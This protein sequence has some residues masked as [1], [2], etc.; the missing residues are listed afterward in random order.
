MGRADWNINDKWRLFIRAVRDKDYRLEPYGWSSV[1]VSNMPFGSYVGFPGKSTVANL[2]TVINPTLTN[3]FIFGVSWNHVYVRTQPDISP[4]YYKKD[5]GLSYQMPFPAAD[6]LG[7]VQSWT[8]GGVPNGPSVNLGGN[9][10][11]N[12]NAVFE[13]T[14]NLSKVY[15]SDMFK[16]GLFIH[17]QRKNQTAFSPVNGNISF[18]RDSGNPADSN[19][20]FSNALLGNYTTVQQADI[21]RNGKYRYT[22]A[23]WYLANTWKVRPNLTLD[24]GLRFYIV[25]PQYDA[26]MQLSSF[27]V[28]LWDPKKAALLYRRARDPAGNIAARDPITGAHYPA[29]FIGGLVPGTGYRLGDAYINGIAMAGVNDY[30]RGLIDSRGLHYAPRVGL[31]WSFMNKTVFRMGGGV[32]YDRFQG[33][34]CYAML[35]NPPATVTPTL[36][37]GSLTNIASA[38]SMLFPGTIRGFS[39]DGHVS[40]VYNYNAGL[41]RELPFQML[42]D[43]SYVGNVGRHGLYGY[44]LNRPGFGSAW[45]PQNQDPT[46]TPKFDGTTTLPVNFYRPYQ[47]HGSIN[48]YEFGASSNYNSLQVS[49]NRRLATGLQLGVAYT[50]SKSLGI[51]TGDATAM[52]PTNIRQAMYAPNGNDR[53]HILVFNYIYNT[54]KLARSGNVLDNWLGRAVF[55]GW[56]VSGITT[57]QTGAPDSVSYSISGVSQLARLVTGDETWGPRVVLTGQDPF[58]PKDK[59]NENSWFTAGA[60][61]P[62]VKPSVGLESAVRGYIYGPG[63]NHWDVSVF[64]SFPFSADGSRFVQLRLEMFNAPNHT[65]YSG[66]NTSIVFDSAGKVTNLPTALGGGGG[67]F[68]FGAVTSARDPR[69]IQLAAKI[70]F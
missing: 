61:A 8:W 10:F 9:P 14:D 47:G 43:V 12:M 41:Q 38:T 15:S 2:T 67:R 32:F 3:E 55:N 23:E 42:L 7:V 1:V 52:H 54:P 33:N 56:V 69:I 50:W 46:T 59:R 35:T 37:Y 53:R 24:L 64:K 51:S 62:A 11:V 22:N 57:I 27:N 45:L 29:A 16:F 4:K 18:A 34:P 31:A 44:D 60:F 13:F 39:K 26:G 5:L 49:L 28:E 30:P 58:V 63:T 68:G 70:Y 19:W 17:R 40:T 6:S 66:V 21:I 65:Q 25:Q 36:Y 48:M 20:A